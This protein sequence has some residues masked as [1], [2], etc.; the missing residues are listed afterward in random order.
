[1]ADAKKVFQELAEDPSARF[2]APY[3]LLSLGDI[4]KAAGDAEQAAKFYQK[5]KNDFADSSF[6]SV[7][8][9]RISMLKAQMPV[10]VDAPPPPPP[11]APVPPAKPE[12]AVA[13][14]KDPSTPP[15]AAPSVETVPPATQVLPAVPEAPA[16]VQDSPAAPRS[17]SDEKPAAAAPPLKP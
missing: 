4:A 7:I 16:P 8:S 17:N 10:E 15:P 14:V 12:A 13:P 1:M 5:A 11:P 9:Q 3:A 6:S 2:L